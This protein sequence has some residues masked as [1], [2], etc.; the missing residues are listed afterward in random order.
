MLFLDLE[1]NNTNIKK[2]INNLYILNKQISIKY[3]N[4]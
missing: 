3:L 2:F 1:T 4:I